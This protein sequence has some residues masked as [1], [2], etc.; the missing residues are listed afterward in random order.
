MPKVSVI[1]PTYNTAKYINFAIESVLNQTYTDYEIIVV[2]DGSTDNTKEVLKRYWGKIRYF[3]QQNQGVSYARNLAINHAKGRYIA[4]LDSDDEWLPDRLSEGVSI[5]DNR[6]EVGLVH[7]DYT[8]ITEDGNILQQYNINNKKNLKYVSGDI[9]KYI[10]FRKAH[11]N[12]LT[13]IFRKSCIESV[14]N[15]D[16]NLSKLGAEDR[17]LWYR[18]SRV[19]KIYYINKSLALCRARPNSMSSNT[20]NM[21]KARCYIINKYYPHKKGLNIMRQKLFSALYL[22][23]GDGISWRYKDYIGAIKQYKKAINFFPL[24]FIAYY[25]LLK[26]VIN[27]IL[28]L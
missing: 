22:S 2:D 10:L 20:K 5:L 1:I 18:I 26:A 9:S 17:D 13:V 16:I 12:C 7:S 25:H 21:M 24:N 6:K 8:V 11:I 28:K 4:L 14:G 3:Y 27:K 23:E 15:F 19:Y